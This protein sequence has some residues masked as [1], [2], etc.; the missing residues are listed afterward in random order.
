[1]P[2]LRWVGTVEVHVAAA[3]EATMFVLCMDVR[4]CNAFPRCTHPS[5]DVVQHEGAAIQYTL[6][7]YIEQ[8]LSSGLSRL[9]DAVGMRMTSVRSWQPLSWNSCSISASV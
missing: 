4:L 5:L 7:P 2:V 6:S 3:Y 9:A 1:M 8:E